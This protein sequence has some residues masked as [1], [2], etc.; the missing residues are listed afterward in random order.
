M[1]KE[2]MPDVKIE[3]WMRPLATKIVTDSANAVVTYPHQLQDLIEEAMRDIATAYAAR[4]Q[5][6]ELRDAVLLL[7]IADHEG[8]WPPDAD[9]EHLYERDL[10]ANR[11]D[12]T[13]EYTAWIT[14]KGYEVIKRALKSALSTRSLTDERTDRE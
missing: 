5:D 7:T 9:C 11:Q 10:L 8:L 6:G 12:M 13:G 1:N 2:T 14:E 4:E 3:P